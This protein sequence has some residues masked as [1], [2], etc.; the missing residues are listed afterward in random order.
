MAACLEDGGG[1]LSVVAVAVAGCSCEAIELEVVTAI[2]LVIV[3]LAVASFAATRRCCSNTESSLSVSFRFLLP[4]FELNMAVSAA[5]ANEYMNTVV[6]TWTQ[7]SYFYENR[8]RKISS[9]IRHDICRRVFYS[10]TNNINVQYRKV[11]TLHM[12]IIHL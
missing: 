8:E 4:L 1:L 7:V 3:F 10:W 2:V 5:V 12:Y 11:Y 6:V 9:G